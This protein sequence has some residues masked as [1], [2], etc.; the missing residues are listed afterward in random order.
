MDQ[1]SGIANSTY[2][3]HVN[4]YGYAIYGNASDAGGVRLRFLIG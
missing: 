4:Y 2:F 3:C 1:D